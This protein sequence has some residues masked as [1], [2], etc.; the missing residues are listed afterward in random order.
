MLS[1]NLISRIYL[2]VFVVILRLSLFRIDAVP[3]ASCENGLHTGVRNKLN[4]EDDARIE[5]VI[6]MKL[7][8]LNERENHTTFDLME[9]HSTTVRL[10]VGLMY[11][12]IADVKLNQ[13]I[14][15]CAI[16]FWV[17]PW[18]NANKFQMNCDDI[19]K[20]YGYQLIDGNLSRM[21]DNEMFEFSERL[22][23]ALKQYE[24][25]VDGLIVHEIVRAE[26]V[27]GTVNGIIELANVKFQKQQQHNT[28]NTIN[29]INNNNNN[30][31][32]TSTMECAVEAWE[33]PPSTFLDLHIACKSN[34]YTIISKLYATKSRSCDK[35]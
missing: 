8:G 33:S 26:R 22:M 15:H 7:M 31:N 1:T 16:E 4:S 28:T 32:S 21:N 6:K 17:M 35:K 11:E 19:N 29:I 30:N 18:L 5:Q 23:N 14:C 12:T 27:V 9:I 13:S 34:V 3:L 10:T 2:T 25:S 20:L 24:K